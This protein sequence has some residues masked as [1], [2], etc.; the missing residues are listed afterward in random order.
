MDQDN[1][2]LASDA[3]LLEPMPREPRDLND[4]K[5][6]PPRI[7]STAPYHSD[8]QFDVWHTRISSMCEVGLPPG[9]SAADGFE[10]EY[11]A[12]NMTHVILTA[13]HHPAQTL[14]RTPDP[15]RRSPVDHWWLFY[16]RSGEAWFETADRQ[17]H[18]QPGDMFLMSL[19]QAFHGRITD[20]D[21]L[22]LGMP[23]EAFTAVAADLDSVC[24]TVLSGNLAGL[25]ADHLHHLQMRVVGMTPD[26]LLQ[27][28]RA[29]ADMIAACIQPSRD[30]LEQARGPF[31]S[32]LFERARLYIQAHLGEPDL[33]PEHVAQALRISRSN[34][35]RTFEHAGGVAHYIQRA[36]LLAAH[37]ELATG[38]EKR[39]QEVANSHGF[40]LASDFA[41]AF[42][43]EFGYSPREA[44]DQQRR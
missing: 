19:D 7:L 13:G 36:R 24:N 29:T 14:T 32:I 16:P 20:Y 43:R 17:I 34:L 8:E 28:G 22:L 15:G 39:V 21:A 3:K 35:Y 31:E 2:I 18:A 26:E 42:R 44:R 10:V 37:T 1:F 41:R 11:M 25:L 30:R 33:T 40:K 38:A 6:A 9:S 5:P 4:R 12:C 27:A 23:R